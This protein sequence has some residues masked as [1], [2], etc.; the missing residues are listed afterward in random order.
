[1]GFAA[2]IASLFC[3]GLSP[4]TAAQAAYPA[5]SGYSAQ[6]KRP[7]FRPWSR[8]ERQTP[9]ARWRPQATSAARAVSRPDSWR[10]PVTFGTQPSR[11][12]AASRGSSSVR[13]AA[14]RTP[15]Q[16]PGVVF[17]PDDRQAATAGEASDDNS[18]RDPRRSALHAQFRPTGD[19]KR[20]TTYNDMQAA[21]AG[22]PGFRMPIAPVAA[23]SAPPLPVPP[24]YGRYW[25][26]W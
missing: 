21:T 26:H 17:R 12:L 18:I 24:P 11:A 23:F 20:K 10:R 6:V 2:G 3:V 1:M 19:R 15:L 5:W 9:T 7:Q 14:P 22:P 13:Y 4:M 25:P 8:S 16:R